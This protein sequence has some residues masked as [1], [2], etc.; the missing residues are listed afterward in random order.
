M[1]ITTINSWRYQSG[2]PTP[3]TIS[4]G[5]DRLLVARIGFLKLSANKTN[6]TTPTLTYG[7]QI[8]SRHVISPFGQNSYNQ[9]GLGLFTLSESGIAAIGSNGFSLSWSNYTPDYYDSFIEAFS[10]T[11]NIEYKKAESGINIYVDKL[12]TSHSVLAGDTIRASYIARATDRLISWNINELH[13]GYP[14]TGYNDS[15][16][17]K[18]IQSDGTQTIQAS[19]DTYANSCLVSLRIQRKTTVQEQESI[20]ANA[21]AGSSLNADIIRE[22]AEVSHGSLSWDSFFPIQEGDENQYTDHFFAKG[23]LVSDSDMNRVADNIRLVRTSEVSSF[24]PIN[25]VE[26]QFWLD[27]SNPAS[28]Q[29]S[30]ITPGDQLIV[31][32]A[33]DPVN[34]TPDFSPA[35]GGNQFQEGTLTTNKFASGQLTNPDF[36]DGAF[37][38]DKIYGASQ[39]RFGASAIG[40]GT[41]AENSVNYPNINSGAIHA[42]HLDL[43]VGSVSGSSSNVTIQFNKF[44]LMPDFRSSST[45]MRISGH[46]GTPD[47]DNP[48]LRLDG[49]G[50]SYSYS[51]AWYYFDE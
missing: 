22:Y 37:T 47:V 12:I 19:I 32:F 29:M 6:I 50:S 24:E 38:K 26:G 3:L 20:I 25:K 10:E 49:Q 44:S 7:G 46:T 41:L 39:S 45:N 51:V 11:G 23:Q 28:Y 18:N 27:I 36:S 30:I 5:A 42:N 21:S 4:A 1:A 33:I 2:N 8:M 17:Y 35:F 34:H 40:S 14:H 9:G 15:E 13:E 31:A 48:K 16:A 43:L